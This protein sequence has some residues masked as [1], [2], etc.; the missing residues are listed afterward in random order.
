MRHAQSEA[1]GLSI[2]DKCALYR[3]KGDAYIGLSATGEERALRFGYHL[4]PHGEYKKLF[5]V[6]GNDTRCRETA[7]LIAKA[8]KAI[9][10]DRNIIGLGQIPELSKQNFGALDGY[11][12]D[13]EREVYAPQAHCAFQKAVR[14]YGEIDARPQGGESYRDLAQRLDNARKQLKFTRACYDDEFGSEQVAILGI[15]N[16]TNILLLNALNDDAPIETVLPY[17]DKVRNLEGVNLRL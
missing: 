3:E 2:E 1:Q 9:G 11:L 6:Y 14:E 5:I 13:R 12:T 7:Q 15:T 4:F 10:N 8:F 17:V 16:G